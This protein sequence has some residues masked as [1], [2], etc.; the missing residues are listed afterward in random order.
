MRGKPSA[1][2]RSTSARLVAVG[3]NA[4]SCC[5]PSR[6]KHSQSVTASIVDSINELVLRCQ[7]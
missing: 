1:A 2:K 3:T 6:A 4:G 7:R 5:S